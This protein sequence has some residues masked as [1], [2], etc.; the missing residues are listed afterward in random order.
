MSSPT[1]PTPDEWASIRETIKFQRVLGNPRRAALECLGVECVRRIRHLLTPE[2]L[3]L[4]DVIEAYAEGRTER[5]AVL[6]ATQS[7]ELD[8]GPR[9]F[10]TSESAASAAAYLMV[11]DVLHP[12]DARFLSTNRLFILVEGV[13]YECR[14]A[15]METI[16][17]VNWEEAELPPDLEPARAELFALSPDERHELWA[18]PGINPKFL[19]V[20]WAL[21]AASREREAQQKPLGEAEELAQCD[22]VREIVQPPFVTE[23]SHEFRTSTVL[24]LARDIYEKRAF[25]Q[26][27]ILADALQDAGCDNEHILNHCRDTSAKHVRGCWVLALVLETVGDGKHRS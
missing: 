11:G 2:S 24:A 17:A 7:L 22:L 1:I 16:P 26:M 18:T 27:P 14:R 21:D 13:A 25:D 4:A 9:N 8:I 15:V 19:A 10:V 5:A 3:Q 20:M 6:D 23:F 12:D